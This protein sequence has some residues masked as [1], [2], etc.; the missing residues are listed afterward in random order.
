MA[1]VR[2]QTAKALRYS[3]TASVGMAKDQRMVIRIGWGILAGLG[4][5]KT[6][7]VDLLWGHGDDFGSICL[8][9]CRDGGYMLLQHGRTTQ[10]LQFST[11]RVCRQEIADRDKAVWRFVITQRPRRNVRHYQLPDGRLGLELPLDWF[12]LVRPARKLKAV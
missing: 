5:S 9:K 10:S 4:W 2:P 12:E 3:L 7:R 8:A 6:T 1:F 11:L